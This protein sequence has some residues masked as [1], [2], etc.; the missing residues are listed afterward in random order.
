MPNPPTIAHVY[1]WDNNMVMT[2]DQNGQQMPEYQGTKE[3]VWEKIMRDKTDETVI[4][5][6]DWAEYRGKS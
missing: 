1:L 3:E 4:G 2:F 5:G 6:A